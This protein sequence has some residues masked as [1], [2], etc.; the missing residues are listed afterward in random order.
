MLKK[1]DSQFALAIAVSADWGLVTQAFL[2]LIDKNAHDIAKTHSEIQALKDVLR[3]LFVEGAVFSSSGTHQ[4]TKLREVPAIGG[5]FGTKG[6]KPMFV[7]QWNEHTLRTQLSSIVE[8]SKFTRWG[9][10]RKV[11]SRKP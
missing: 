2:R 5:Y 10:P 6:V 1:L 4:G 7:T 3:I 9:Y 8:M 11:R